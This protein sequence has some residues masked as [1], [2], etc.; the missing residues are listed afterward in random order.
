MNVME[1]RQILSWLMDMDGVLV[2]EEDPIPG[3][4]EFLA[5][6]RERQV[7]AQIVLISGHDGGT[8]ASP[9]TSLKHAG[10]PW[11]LGLAETQQLLAEGRETFLQPHAEALVV[12]VDTEGVLPLVGTQSHGVQLALQAFSG[13]DLKFFRVSRQAHR[14]SKPFATQLQR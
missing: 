3:A 12:E 11:E 14:S 2:R 7:D 8:G 1:K 5:R 6:L 10:G 9:L 13:N 4:A